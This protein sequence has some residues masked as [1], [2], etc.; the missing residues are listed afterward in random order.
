MEKYLTYTDQDGQVYL[1]NHPDN[2]A[3]FAK[4]NK[5]IKTFFY[6]GTCCCEEEDLEPLANGVFQYN[7]QAYLE[8]I[9]KAFRK[10]K[11]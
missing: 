4:E 10:E 8:A 1:A 3:K 11:K 5:K 7:R 6:S 2:F 9:K